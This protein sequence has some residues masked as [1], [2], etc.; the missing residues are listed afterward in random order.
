ML[1]RYFLVSTFSHGIPATIAA[2]FRSQYLYWLFLLPWFDGST[3]D[4]CT[5]ANMAWFP[6]SHLTS[7]GCSTNFLFYCTGKR[8]VVDI[9]AKI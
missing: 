1:L 3:L 4:S 7:L 6:I 5:H 2:N 8:A 9:E